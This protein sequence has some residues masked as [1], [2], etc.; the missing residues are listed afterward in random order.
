MVD[1]NKINN[2]EQIREEKKLEAEKLRNKAVLREQDGKSQLKEEVD[3]KETEKVLNSKYNN[4][5]VGYPEEDTEDKGLDLKKR[6]IDEANNDKMENRVHLKQ[7][8]NEAAEE[9]YKARNK[10]FKK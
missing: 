7:A 10:N 8:R 4:E 2:I 9:G 3:L 6:A 5:D 1:D